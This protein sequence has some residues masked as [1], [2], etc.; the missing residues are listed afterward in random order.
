MQS[1]LSNPANSLPGRLGGAP[2][3][4]SPTPTSRR[5]NEPSAPTLAESPDPSNWPPSF[6]T[7]FLNTK[8]FFK[9]SALSLS[10]QN[11]RIKKGDTKGHSQ[12]YICTT[13]I[14]TTFRCNPSTSCLPYYVGIIRQFKKPSLYPP[15]QNTSQ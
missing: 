1:K 14:T 2:G 11:M 6:Q 7:F 3:T 5:Q 15:T 12:Q 9:L 13:Y 8:L 4:P 10:A